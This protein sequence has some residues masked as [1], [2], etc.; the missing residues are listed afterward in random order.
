MVIK[1]DDLEKYS[2]C[3]LIN[4]IE[5]PEPFATS[6]E[7]LNWV[8]IQ[9]ASSYIPD[10]ED[11]RANFIFNWKLKHTVQDFD[12]WVGPQRAA[13]IAVRL[14][15]L[16]LNYKCIIPMTGYKYTIGDNTIEGQ[17]ALLTDDKKYPR[18]YVLNPIVIAPPGKKPVFTEYKALARW[19]YIRNT[20]DNAELSILHFPLLYGVSWKDRYID[21]SLAK[22]WLDS[23]LKTASNIQYPRA[24]TY[25]RQCSA[26]C[27]ELYG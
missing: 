16:A 18:S 26:P 20:Y 23:I 7:T 8:L 5:E 21:E 17:V 1:E 12:Y 10:L 24:G 11:I 4:K 13:S 14:Y 27:K 25:C 2:T 6:I 15:K 19:L 3:I 22:K 9:L